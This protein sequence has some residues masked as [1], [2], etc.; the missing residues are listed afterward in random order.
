MCPWLCSKADTDLGDCCTDGDSQ[1][2]ETVL[3]QL[4]Q[5]KRG[6]CSEHQAAATAGGS[7]PLIGG[8]RCRWFPPHRSH[9]CP[10]GSPSPC[11]QN[12]VSSWLSSKRPTACQAPELSLQGRS[13]NPSSASHLSP[14]RMR[15]V[16]I[17][18]KHPA[19]PPP[20]AAQRGCW[21]SPQH[22]SAYGCHV[23]CPALGHHFCSID[24]VG[25]PRPRDVPPLP[26]GSSTP[27]RRHCQGWFSAKQ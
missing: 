13:P 15:T 4:P 10:R 12:E 6:S 16:S 18:P 26:L 19:C 21:A 1:T 20:P 5:C 7:G 3:E 22:P 9:S 2:N 11:F 27:H 17:S 23:L 25:A 14:W 8:S 24:A